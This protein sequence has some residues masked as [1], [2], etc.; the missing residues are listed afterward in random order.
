MKRNLRAGTE[1]TNCPRCRKPF[2]EVPAAEAATL[3]ERL[4]GHLR[5]VRSWGCYTP[6]RGKA[7]PG[8]HGAWPLHYWRG[9]GTFPLVIEFAKKGERPTFEQFC[10]VYGLR[11][12]E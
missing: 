1:T 8:E 5:V 12:I 2:R 9:P 6:S 7:Q 11:P 3:Y 4:R 10:K